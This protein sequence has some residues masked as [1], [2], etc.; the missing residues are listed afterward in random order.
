MANLESGET[1]LYISE[2]EFGVA[3]DDCVKTIRELEAM[4]HV[5]IRID[6]AENLPMLRADRRMV[7]QMLLNLVLNAVKFSPQGGDV[8]VSPEYDGE[9]DFCLSVTDAGSGMS[10]QQVAAVF[11]MFQTTDQGVSDSAPGYRIGLAGDDS[12]DRRTWRQY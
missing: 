8:L 1:K 11:E 5:T 12:N 10:P 9:G 2:F 3:L 7:D 4:E 6:G